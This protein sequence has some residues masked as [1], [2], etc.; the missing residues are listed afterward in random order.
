MPVPL[1]DL[2]AQHE[3]LLPQMHEIFD[4]TVR[5]G[6]FV[7][8]PDLA[9]FEQGLARV[10]DTRHAI[11]LSSGTDA[12][13]AAMMALGLAA[14][15]EVIVPTF[16]FFSTAGCVTRLGAKPVFVDVDPQTCT[17]CPQATR[18][19]L[20]DRTR[21]IVPVHLFGQTADMTA[22]LEIASSR[23]VP[24]IEDAAQAIGAA[25]HG[26]MAGAMGDVGC[27]SFYPSKNLAG[28]GDSGAC[29]TAND[30]L[31]ARIRML[32]AHGEHGGRYECVGGNFRMD[33]LTAALLQLKLSFLDGWTQARRAHAG[34]YDELF[35]DLP[36]VC[37]REREGCLH[38]Y[39]QYTIRVGEGR[40]DDLAA[41]LEQRSI[42]N[43]VYYPL[44]LHLQP[45]YEALGG[46]PGDC[47]VA[48]QACAEVLSLPVYPEMSVTQQDEVVAA[49]RDFFK[50]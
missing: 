44:P 36:V 30:A 5:A 9:V 29:V 47:P 12:L 28:P 39:N 42:G 38:V 35:E 41:F 1:L 2:T 10:C 6:Q 49:L 22:L 27:L 43:R 7:L 19:A 37:P 21:A 34:R 17:I 4:R 15:D 23:E 40:R 20:T 3:A 18:R 16:T 31:A 11:G 32:R 14:G 26:R 25:D 8:G 45:C 13:L 33:T 50:A 48:E 46:R 24:V